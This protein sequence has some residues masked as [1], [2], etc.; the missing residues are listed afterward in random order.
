MTPSSEH[1]RHLVLHAD[2]LGFTFGFTDAI[3]QAH[4]RGNLTSTCLQVN[5]IAYEHARRDVLPDCPELGVGVHLNVVECRS[6][7]G[8]R[9]I[10]ALVDVDGH[11]RGYGPILR[12]SI[13]RHVRRQILEEFR[14]QIER[15]LADGLEL[16]HV[17][18]HRHVHMLPWLFDGVCDL[19]GRF[20]IPFV[21]LTSE[22][23]HRPQPSGRGRYLSRDGNWAKLALMSLMAVPNRRR[24]ERHGV[25]SNDGFVG[26]SFT[27]HGSAEAIRRGLA[28]NPGSIVEVLIHPSVRRH[29]ADV[30]RLPATVQRYCDAPARG[31]EFQA[32]CSPGL[33]REIEQLGYRLT[34]YRRIAEGRRAEVSPDH[35]AGGMSRNKTAVAARARA[36]RMHAVTT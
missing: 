35:R 27:G 1:P 6:C 17:N 34:S 24:L 21:R 20:G 33:R 32:A 19:A 23:F 8:A 29:P 16:D 7:L 22:R 3:H 10:P 15:A 18:S 30:G 5:G 31:V 26:L 12:A 14:A 4:K 9:L 11:F 36:L 28:A 13:S 25:R 2:D